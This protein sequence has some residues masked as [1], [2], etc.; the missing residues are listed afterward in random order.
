MTCTIITQ[1]SSNT[2]L[3]VFHSLTDTTVGI[4][5]CHNVASH[6]QT[7]YTS[8]TE[9]MVQSPA[10]VP[11]LPDNRRLGNI[12]LY[13]C[14]VVETLNETTPPPRRRELTHRI[15]VRSSDG[16]QQQKIATMKALAIYVPESVGPITEGMEYNVRSKK[17]QNS[18]Y[19]RDIEFH[20]SLS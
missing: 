4:R 13:R 20:Q 16:Q 5:A 3:S 14:I 11:V 18:V 8:P 9:Y 1:T 19:T 15:H 17:I 12:S 10:L 7:L 6:C 2:S